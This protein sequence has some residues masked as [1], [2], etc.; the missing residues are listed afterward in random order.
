MQLVQKINKAT[1]EAEQIPFE[2]AVNELGHS[3]LTKLYEE[4]PD[5]FETPEDATVPDMGIWL[6]VSRELMEGDVVE[7]NTHR[8]LAI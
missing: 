2:Q 7:T 1:D 6:D 4:D 5:S 8:Y 3:V